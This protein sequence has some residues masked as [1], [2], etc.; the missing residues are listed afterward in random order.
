MKKY[1]LV[2]EEKVQR[3]SDTPFKG[4][5][6]LIFPE[7]LDEDK[8]CMG[9]EYQIHP[10]KVIAK[11]VY[12]ELPPVTKAKKQ[13]ERDETSFIRYSG[14]RFPLN[15]E[16]ITLLTAYV[17]AGIDKIQWKCVKGWKTLS[18]EEAKELLV[19]LTTEKNKLFKK[20]RNDAGPEEEDTEKDE[21]DA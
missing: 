15:N 11:P 12:E 5:T 4:S 14:R 8:A 10:T 3:V 18:V 17:V 20:E 19:L 7:S 13:R 1:C 21:G 6:P 2:K 16:T 9:Y